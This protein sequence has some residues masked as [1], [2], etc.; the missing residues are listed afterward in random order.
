MRVKKV[1]RSTAL[2]FWPV[3]VIAALLIGSLRGAQASVPVEVGYQDFSFPA[4][5]GVNS[6][7]TAEKP[8]SKL[9]WNDGFWWASM[10][11]TAGNAY[12]IYRLDLATQSWVD[13]GTALDDRSDT[14]ADALWDGQHLYLVSHI[15]TGMGAASS[16]PTKW[17][18]LYRY[19]YNAGT[20]TYTPDAG[21]PVNVT[22]GKSETLVVDKDSTGQL[23]VTYVETTQ[24]LINHSLNGDD[25]AWSTP[26]V[27]PVDNTTGL[28]SDDISSVIAF[29][30]R[31]G[32]M[33]S[34]QNQSTKKMYFAGYVDGDPATAWQGVAAYSVS[35]DDH[36]NLKSLQTDSAGNV[37]AA[38]KTSRSSALIVLL[39][40]RSLACVAANDW[41]AYTVYDSGEFNPTRPILLIDTENRTLYVFTRSRETAGQPGIYFKSA[42]M[43]N[44]Q[45]PTGVG[46]KFIKNAADD[47]IN[48]PTSTK[49]N[50]NSS[51]GLVVLASDSATKYYFHNYLSLSGG[52]PTSTP[53]NTA[54]A[55]PSPTPSN[56]PTPTSTPIGGSRIKDTTFEDGSLTH[57]VSGADSVNGTVVL[58][59]ASPLKGL[60]SADFPSVSNSYLTENFSGVDDLYVSFYLKVNS[61]PASL[62]TLAKITNAGAMVG[63]LQ[64]RP[65]GALRLRNNTTTIGADSA[66][67]TVGAIYRVGLRQR[68]GT[69]G[70][71]ILEAYLAAGDD[72][73]GAPFASTTT[74]TW[75]SQ[76][77][78]FQA[79]VT[80]SNILDATFDDIRLDSG[81]MPG[82]GDPAPTPTPTNTPTVGPSP[83]PS[84]TPTPTSTPIV[85][86]RIKDITFEDGSL[87]HPVSGADSVNGT[88]VLESAAPLKGVFSADIPSVS[89]S[90]LTENFTGV[91]DLY[92]SFY[93]KVNS[94][95]ASFVTLAKITDA[96]IMVGNLQLRSTGGLRV[97]RDTTTIGADSAPL[98]VGA[99]YRVG[100]R[101]RRGVGGD[102]ILEAYLALGDAPFGAPFASTTT[103]NWTSQADRFQ[104]GVT[105]SNI[106]D[107]TFDDLRLD[108][109]A[110]PGPSQ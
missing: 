68:R 10:W 94:L 26:F 49:Q 66:P 75:T 33:W 34:N 54:T 77:N 24:V 50:L 16:D 25:S 81:S 72:L 31:V 86:P 53:T 107:A 70:D 27:L 87:T 90:Y 58:D 9:W 82:P 57:P 5:T 55:G 105:G 42:D 38:I 99:I 46:T 84:D 80:G 89:N 101:Q 59:S 4:G 8:E 92:V 97:R 85:G 62:V 51:T 43:D 7:V 63:N 100:L 98:T 2:Y 47:G 109:A 65:T 40:C 41:S 67:L 76:A 73:F 104:A 22:Q 11:S 3:A 110:M 108:S 36:I 52:S 45:F 91:D 23:W 6:E 19:S 1:Y 106:L 88:V 93:L 60:Y 21:F 14:K 102:A 74:G 12:H 13:T 29:G 28:T 32:M 64:L 79:G 44:I 103:G 35:A 37:F 95:P 71:A 56:T 48:D 39:V 78:R 17:G 61:L 69:G 83:T 15:W 30:G 96:G 18:R 20:D